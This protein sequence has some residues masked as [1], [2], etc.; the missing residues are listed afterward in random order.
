MA[1]QSKMLH[2]PVL[3]IYFIYFRLTGVVIFPVKIFK[4]L[5]S[6]IMSFIPTRRNDGEKNDENLGM[7]RFF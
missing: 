7:I 2:K 1:A 6:L 5:L 4:S 3:Y